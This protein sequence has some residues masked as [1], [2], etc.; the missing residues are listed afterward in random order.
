MN[1]IR[2]NLCFSGTAFGDSIFISGDRPQPPRQIFMF[3]Y[4]IIRRIPHTVQVPSVSMHISDQYA[5]TITQESMN[6]EV[7][8]NMSSPIE[9]TSHTAQHSTENKN[10]KGKCLSD[11]WSDERDQKKRKIILFCCRLSL[12]AFGCFSLFLSLLRSV[13]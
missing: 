12:A 11:A 8:P 1:S 5:I 4:P 9:V 10:E 7:N 6:N 2:L 3:I 13:A